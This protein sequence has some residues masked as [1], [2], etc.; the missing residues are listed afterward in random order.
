LAFLFSP[1]QKPNLRHNG[2]KAGIRSKNPIRADR[3]D[4]RAAKRPNNVIWM[5]EKTA[6]DG[7]RPRGSVPDAAARL[8]LEPGVRYSL[9]KAKRWEIVKDPESL[10]MLNDSDDSDASAS[11]SGDE[12]G[13]DGAHRKLR[14]GVA[15]GHGN[16]R[17][18]RPTH[19]VQAERRFQDDSF[20]NQPAAEP[21]PDEM[22]Y[23]V[24]KSRKGHG[25]IVAKMPKGKKAPGVKPNAAP[26]VVYDLAAADKLYIVE[27]GYNYRNWCNH[28][29]K[30]HRHCGMC[31]PVHKGENK[32]IKNPKVSLRMLND[33]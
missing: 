12:A 33:L 6:P 9:D 16:G 31:N 24:R 11:S 3:D 29:Q 30:H 18:G 7:S 2:S 4:L 27:S 13:H 5:R 28:R 8:N 32:D 15:G 25:E 26:Q 23:V 20:R 17:T 22:E 1:P 10:T 19:A 14:V 21:S